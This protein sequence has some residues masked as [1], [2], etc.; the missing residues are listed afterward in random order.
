MHSFLT[1]ALISGG[2]FLLS[3]A[4][5]PRTESHEDYI[6]ELEYENS[7]LRSQLANAQ[8]GASEAMDAAQ[9]AQ[10]A[11]QSA[12]TEADRCGGEDWSHVGGGVQ[13]AADDAMHAG[14]NAYEQVSEIVDAV[15]Y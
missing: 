1:R 11:A 8:S 2:V 13:S 4:S 3:C 12:Q 5:G 10:I 7:E 15:E 6:A 14:D 9:S